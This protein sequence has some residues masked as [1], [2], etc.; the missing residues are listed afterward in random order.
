RPCPLQAHVVILAIGCLFCLVLESELEHRSRTAAMG[1]ALLCEVTLLSHRS[2]AESAVPPPAASADMERACGVD[3]GLLPCL[4]GSSAADEAGGWSGQDRAWGQEGS[5]SHSPAAETGPRP[6]RSGG[7]RISRRCRR[8]RRR[9]RIRRSPAR[10][11]FRRSP[12]S[13]PAAVPPVGGAAKRSPNATPEEWHPG[14][15]PMFFVKG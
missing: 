14:G 3:R 15:A 5:L 4:R 1:G 13:S 9:R 12:I 7:H 6:M 2:R 10:N 11:R 8:H